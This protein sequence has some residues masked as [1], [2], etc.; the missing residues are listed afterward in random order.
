MAGEA[1]QFRREIDLGDG[2]GKQV[3]EAES[4]EELNDVLATA[5]TNATRKIREQ[6]E[7]LKT[8]RRA[9]LNA[10][11]RGE[12]DP[13]GPM[14]SFK[15]RPLTADEKFALGQRLLNPATAVD[16][17]TEAIELGMGANLDQVRRSL[18]R[19]ETTPRELRGKEAAEAF[20]LTHPEFVVNAANQQE[21]FAYLEHPDRRMLPTVRNFERAFQ[22][23]KA[24][25]LLQLQAVAPAGNGNGSDGNGK[26][27]AD[28]EERPA[29]ENRPRFASTSVV[30]R[31][32]GT[33][34]GSAVPKMPSDEE[35]E[36]MGPIEHKKWLAVPGFMEHE[37]R[38]IQQKS[39]RRQ[40]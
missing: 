22:A 4:A 23:C 15:A 31:G 11:A 19:A 30:T 7:E 35:I 32:S 3:F 9:A 25:G 2:S 5:Q 13:D 1:K 18:L 10:P 38:L 17:L 28:S 8:L 21:I 14:P 36:R 12:D 27:S 20:L 33:P 26:P 6:N 29:P 34:R 40:A 39:R 37:E 24:A 16:A